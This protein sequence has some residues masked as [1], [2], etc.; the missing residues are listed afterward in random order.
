LGQALGAGD[1]PADP[2]LLIV[3]RLG[4][5][6]VRR[7]QL[8]AFQGALLAPGAILLVVLLV[9]P[10]ALMAVESFHPFVAGRVG[11]GAGWTVRNYTELIEPA[12]AFYFYDTFRI[13]FIVSAIALLFATPLAWQAARTK[14]RATRVSIFGL[15]IG[16][17]FMSLVARLYAIQM[18]WG[19]TGPL[20]FFGTL[21]GV[22]AR[23]SGY[24]AI[25]VAIGLLHFVVPMAAMIL[26][27]TFQNISP[28]L[29]EAAASLGAPRWRVAFTV[30][31]PLAIP[32]LLSA[33]M[34]AFA[35]CISNFVVPLILGRGVV[36]FTTNL[37]YVRFSDVANFPS[38]AA[39]GIIMFTL[40][41]VVVYTLAGL[42]RWLAPA[43]ART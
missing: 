27:G 14:R 25:Q 40:A 4:E 17:L 29:E 30:T 37:M 15:L 11:S 1:R 6:V 21:I 5:A 43:E 42:V 13:G 20:A 35:M 39:I 33:F 2:T 3:S 19:S 26:I 36:L 22:P 12:Y 24:A 9:A 23:S 34:I 7:P 18:T 28:R 8:S 16:L 32:G 31:L 38:G 10:I 41:G